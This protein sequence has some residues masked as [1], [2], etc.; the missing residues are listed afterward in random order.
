MRVLCIYYST[1]ISVGLVRITLSGGR[2]LIRLVKLKKSNIQTTTSTLLL[3]PIWVV[4]CW[5]ESITSHKYLI[6]S[7]I[8]PY[9]SL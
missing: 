3:L 2:V 9:V 6:F 4:R 5:G 7:L 8:H 1:R